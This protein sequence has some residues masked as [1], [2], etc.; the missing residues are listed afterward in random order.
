MIGVSVDFLRVNIFFMKASVSYRFCYSLD[1]N[2]WGREGRVSVVVVLV[3]VVVA[4]AVVV[5]SVVVVVRVGA[6]GRWCCAMAFGL[7][8]WVVLGCGF[9]VVACGCVYPKP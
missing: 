2:R 4:A 3:V 8:V 7:G 5:A 6:G 1:P 9:C